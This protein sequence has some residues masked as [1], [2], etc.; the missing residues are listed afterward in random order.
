MLEVNKVPFEN[1]K[2]ASKYRLLFPSCL[3]RLCAAAARENN[4]DARAIEQETECCSSD[5]F[6]QN[7]C[8]ISWLE[9]YSNAAVFEW[10]E[11]KD[12]KLSS[13]NIPWQFCSQMSKIF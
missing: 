9:N 2:T 12:S 8:Q 1:F 10:C 4:F 3:F 5:F 11:P 6:Q 7:S 13:V